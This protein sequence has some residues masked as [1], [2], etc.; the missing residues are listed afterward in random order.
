MSDSE[1]V[2]NG[3]PSEVFSDTQT[4][5]KAGL[6]LPIATKVSKALIDKGYNIPLALN[7][8]ELVGAICQL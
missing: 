1:I 8:I 2:A 3:T 7:D 4:I 6:D 5:T